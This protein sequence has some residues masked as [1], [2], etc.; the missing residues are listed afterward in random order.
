MAGFAVHTIGGRCH[1]NCNYAMRCC[2]VHSMLDGQAMLRDCE[3]KCTKCI[4]DGEDWQE[5]CKRQE[6]KVFGAMGNAILAELANLRI[7][8]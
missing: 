8:S 2:P 6:D 3:S 5:Q 4:K 1:C 7:E